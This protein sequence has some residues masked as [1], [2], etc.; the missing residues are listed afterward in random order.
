M[1]KVKITQNCVCKNT[2]CDTVKFIK[3]K[4]I[5]ITCNKAQ[6]LWCKT[7][8]DLWRGWK[9]MSNL[10]N[11][12]TWKS[13]WSTLKHVCVL[14]RVVAAH[15]FYAVAQ[16]PIVCVKVKRLMSILRCYSF[17]QWQYTAWCDFTWNIRYDGKIWKTN[18]ILN[19]F[20]YYFE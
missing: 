9:D 17:F 15:N 1:N 11:W 18:K 19:F 7:M 6:S 14:S 5:S 8:T 3:R 10:S 4:I 16:V 2:V 20:G 12:G 13:C